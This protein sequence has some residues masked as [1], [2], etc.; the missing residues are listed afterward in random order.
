MKEQDKLYPSNTQIK[1]MRALKIMFPIVTTT[2]VAIFVPTAVPL[3]GMLMFGN[4]IKEIGSNTSRIYETAANGIMN[5]ATIFLGLSVGA[6]MTVQSFLNW[7]TIGILIGGFFAF[8]LSITAG[9]YMVKLQNH[10]SKKKINPLVGATGLSAVPMASRVSNE[11]ALKYDP[12]NHV[13]NYCMSS[14]ISGVIGSAV[15]AG[16]LISFLQ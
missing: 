6:T 11:I 7:K 3:I 12:S 4:L 9:I 13:L 16:I 5:T 15:A 1:N 2:L 10:F 14:N 8:A